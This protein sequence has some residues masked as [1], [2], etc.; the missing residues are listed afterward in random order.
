MAAYAELG[1]SEPEVEA[2]AE[3]SI[4][5]Y[6]LRNRYGSRIFDLK[7]GPIALALTGLSSPQ[8][9]A[10]LAELHERCS[11]TDELLMELLKARGLSAEA[12]RLDVWR[13]AAAKKKVA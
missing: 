6:L 13:T 2:I 1:V 5:S 10:L 4:G 7:P 11:D 12:M 3:M 8:E 9:L